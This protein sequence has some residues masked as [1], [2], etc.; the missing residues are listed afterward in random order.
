[1]ADVN[2]CPSLGYTREELVAWLE[3][4]P[5]RGGKSSGQSPAAFS[6]VV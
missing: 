5:A 6:G 3:R 4:A 2:A 1:L